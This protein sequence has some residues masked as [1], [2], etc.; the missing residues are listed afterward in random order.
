[1]PSCEQ[2]ELNVWLDQTTLSCQLQLKNDLLNKYQDVKLET[3]SQ[4]SFRSLRAETSLHHTHSVYH[5]FYNPS[6]NVFLKCWL[7]WIHASPSINP[8]SSALQLQTVKN[9][10]ALSQSS[11]WIRSRPLSQSQR[12]QTH[13][14][15][16]NTKSIWISL[17][18]VKCFKLTDEQM[19]G[20]NLKHIQETCKLNSFIWWRAFTFF[21]FQFLLSFKGLITADRHKQTNYSTIIRGEEVDPLS[22]QSYFITVLTLIDHVMLMV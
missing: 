21:I 13:A 22:L 12:R 3:W 2:T 19:M 10:R 15:N 14:M 16:A 1:M 20:N 6:L 5:L 8:P 4:R 18:S 17:N 11:A 9:R 7:V